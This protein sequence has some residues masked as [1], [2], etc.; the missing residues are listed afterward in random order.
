MMKCKEVHHLIATDEVAES[1]WMTRFT[2]RLH[3][4]MCHHCRRYVQHLHAI[5]REFRSLVVKAEPDS[6]TLL[7]M[8]RE[9][10]ARVARG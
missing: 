5:G 1:G 7:R 9:V 10:L 8:E 6:A 4:L 3:V 2:L